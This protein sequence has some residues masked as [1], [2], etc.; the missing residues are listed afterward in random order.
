MISSIIRWIRNRLNC[1]VNWRYN[2]K[3]LF[4]YIGKTSLIFGLIIY[5]SGKA[6]IYGMM[7]PGLIIGGIL[8][9]KGKREK[10]FWPAFIPAVI[11]A[12]L[13]IFFTQSLI[14]ASWMVILLGLPVYAIEFFLDTYHIQEDRVEQHPLNPYPKWAIFIGVF[15]IFANLATLAGG[16]NETSESI[17]S[18]QRMEISQLEPGDKVAGIQEKIEK[19]KGAGTGIEKINIEPGIIGKI[20]ESTS[21]TGSFLWEHIWSA[22]SWFIF[23]IVLTVYATPSEIKDLL[24]NY[25]GG[26]AGAGGGQGVG[27]ASLLYMLQDLFFWLKNLLWRR[28]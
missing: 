2:K 21:D 18:A 17:Q 13:L 15:W 5:L 16:F 23:C 9:I 26:G 25:V 27:F 24:S 8:F 14:F 1:N 6:G 20:R 22:W 28:S 3:T 12:L 19:L 4:G 7:L 10:E 11:V